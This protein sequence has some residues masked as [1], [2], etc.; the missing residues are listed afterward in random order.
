MN[1]PLSIVIP[2]YNVEVYVE[3]CIRSCFDQDVPSGS[4]E[5]IVVNDGATDNSLAI[6][7]RLQQE[8]PSMIIISQ[9]N[10]GLSGA[11]NTGMR[12]AKGDYIWFVD[13]DDWIEK[14]CLKEI[15]S[16]LKNTNPEIL[17]MGHDVIYQ[18]ETVNK[19]IPEK[20][21]HPLNGPEL[22]LNYLNYQY[23]IWKFIYKSSFLHEHSLTFY[24]G[25]LYEDLEFTPRALFFADYCI[26][27]PKIHYHYLLRQGSIANKIRPKNVEHRFWIIDRMINQWEVNREKSTFTQ[28]L[29]Q[30][31]LESFSSTLNT[32]ARTGISLPKTG[33]MLIKKIRSTPELK[34][35]L[36]QSVKIGL[37]FPKSY[38]KCYGL[39]YKVY[40]GIKNL[41]SL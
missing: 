41:R 19:Y 14:D 26:I 32:A 31:I 36:R 29:S 38:C 2:V 30:S 18:G 34:K 11:R 16:K 21:N 22:F 12:H 6:C 33:L 4:Y 37:Y 5:V 40:S 10:R 23:Y 39:A 9:E 7:E 17:W 8:F 27:E 15:I 1:P 35:N 28:A 3:K 25:I 20:A 24:E 13:S